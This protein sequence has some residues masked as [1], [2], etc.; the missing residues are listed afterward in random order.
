MEEVAGIGCSQGRLE[1]KCIA[2]PRRMTWSVIKC[3]KGT[4]ELMAEDYKS[5]Q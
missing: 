3:I 2:I 1:M 5:V 4:E